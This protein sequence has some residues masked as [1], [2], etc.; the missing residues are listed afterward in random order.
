MTGTCGDNQHMNRQAA[1]GSFS[2]KS[3]KEL[4]KVES[5]DPLSNEIG[6]RSETPSRPTG[7][8]G[9]STA[10]YWEAKVY[11]PIWRDEGG[12]RREVSNYFVRIMVSGRREAISLNTADRNE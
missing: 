7:G 4:A 6:P 2:L 11:R 3:G 10:K 9:K 1:T 12:E 8:F 5:S